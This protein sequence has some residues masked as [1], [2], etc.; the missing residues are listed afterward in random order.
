MKSPFYFIVKPV[1]DK[2]YDNTKSI[3]GVELIVST[4]EEDHLFSNRF[5][6]VLELPVNYLGPIQVGDTLVVHHNVF[7]FYNDMKGRRRSG[8]S[9]LRDGLFFVDD[10]QFFMYKRAN[11]W[12]AYGRYCFVKPLPASESFVKKP[13]TNEPLCGIMIYPNKKL[14]TQGVIQGMTVGFTPDSEYEFTIDDEKLYRVFD[15][16]ITMIL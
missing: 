7:K 11:K 1:N 15:H 12:Y 9:F 10:D 13:F 4:S 16:Q 8:R 6:E 3:G 14:I 5:A 2:R